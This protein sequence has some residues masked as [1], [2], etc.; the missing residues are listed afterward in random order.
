MSEDKEK[1][2]P[3]IDLKARLGKTMAAGG[4]AVP[5]PTPGSGSTP[6]PPDGVPAPPPAVTKSA[7]IAPPV[8]LSPGIPL[9][10]FATAAPKKRAPE[11]KPSAQAQTIKVELGEE[12]VEERKKASKKTAIFAVFAAFVGIGVGFVAGGAK[13]RGDDAKITIGGAKDLATEVKAASDKMQEL[14]TVL[15]DAI[16]ELQNKKFPAELAG[17]LAD[18]NIPFD[19]TNLQGKRFGALPGKIPVLMVQ[20]TT[21]VDDLNRKREALRNVAGLAQKPIEEA[22]A[23]EGDPKFKL[24]IAFR[25]SS[26]KLVAELVG[27]K[28]GFKIKESKWPDEFKIVKREFVGGTQ[29]EVEKDA[30]RYQK[31]DLVGG[32]KPKVIPVDPSTSGAFTT[33]RAAVELRKAM[34]DAKEVLNGTE[35]PTDPKPGLIQIGAQLS[36]DLYNASLVL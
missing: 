3:K 19:A 16:Q 36:E 21:G 15:D 13:Q 32:E 20:F 23:E 30:E 28:D 35:H 24:G 18:L 7:G 34:L 8:G 1:K 33:D 9:P 6:P 4:A 5:L 26:D 2:K 27:M 11:P 12:V 25:G 17:K 31:G 14:N 29:K 10:P 22:W